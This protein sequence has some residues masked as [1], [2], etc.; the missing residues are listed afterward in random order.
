MWFKLPS[1]WISQLLLYISL[2]WYFDSNTGEFDIY[3][4]NVLHCCEYYLCLQDVVMIR[5]AQNAAP[6][7]SV[8]RGNGIT[9]FTSHLTSPAQQSVLGLGRGAAGNAAF[10][11]VVLPSSILGPHPAALGIPDLCHLQQ[12]NSRLMG[13]WVFIK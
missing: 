8:G 7:S 2:H 5:N 13:T 4:K 10:G 1:V 3:L 9:H 11:Q 12:Q 6:V